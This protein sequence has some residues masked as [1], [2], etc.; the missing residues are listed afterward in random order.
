[1]KVEAIVRRKTQDLVRD[2]AEDLLRETMEG[3]RRVDRAEL[4]TFEVD[5]E[6]AAERVRAILDET[7]LVVNPNVHRYSL[8]HWNAPPESGVRLFVRVRNRVDARAAQVLR[9]IRERLGRTE[10]TAA[11]R[12]VLWTVDLQSAD[13]AAAERAGRGI[14]G[15][16]RGAGILAN[17]HSEEA[18]VEVVSA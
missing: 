8:E 13:V 2:A 14:I 4:W 1:M 18:S 3:V 7:A 16:E 5:A 11:G 17:P 15:A 9:A 6:D 12:A 10:V